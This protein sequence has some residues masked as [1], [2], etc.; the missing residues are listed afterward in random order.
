M[1]KSPHAKPPA[2]C[3]CD[4]DDWVKGYGYQHGVAVKIGRLWNG[5]TAAGDAHGHQ[6]PECQDGPKTPGEFAQYVA[7]RK[8]AGCLASDAKVSGI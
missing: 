1:M 3:T 7:E 6:V 5:M 8:E 2:W 4:P